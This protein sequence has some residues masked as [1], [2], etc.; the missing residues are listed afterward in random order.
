MLNNYVYWNK[1]AKKYMK[2]S[3]KP[4]KA[5]DEKLISTQRNRGYLIF[6]VTLAKVKSV[7]IQILEKNLIFLSQYYPSSQQFG[8]FFF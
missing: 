8:V 5:L 1:Y 6:L 2:P 7:T 3:R 4:K